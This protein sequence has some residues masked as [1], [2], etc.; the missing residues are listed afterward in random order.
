MLNFHRAKPNRFATVFAI[1][2]CG[3]AAS[4]ADDTGRQSNINS[5]KSQSEEYCSNIGRGTFEKFWFTLTTNT[6]NLGSDPCITPADLKASHH[7]ALDKSYGQTKL[8]DKD[9]RERQSTHYNGTTTSSSTKAIINQVDSIDR[10]MTDGPAKSTNSESLDQ[11]DT[12][13]GYKSVN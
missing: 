3:I 2:A 13:K 6:L 5:T 10:F 11:I 8:N 4:V 9:Y 12:L 7:L 1:C